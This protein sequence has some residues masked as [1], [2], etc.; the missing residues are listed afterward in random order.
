MQRALAQVSMGDAV[1]AAKTLDAAA[2]MDPNY[3]EIHVLYAQVL[4]EAGRLKDALGQYK[5]L[6]AR[7]ASNTTY[8][9]AIKSIEASLSAGAG[10][11]TTP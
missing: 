5:A 9:D 11:T 8:A 1:G 10:T 4:V 6:Q 2:P 3:T 7:D